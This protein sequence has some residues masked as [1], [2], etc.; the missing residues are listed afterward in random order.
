MIKSFKLAA[1]ICLLAVLLSGCGQAAIPEDISEPSLV[2]GRDG[3]VTAYLVG[4]FDKSYYDLSELAVMA[5]EEAAGFGQPAQDGAMPVTLE[6]VSAV[7]DGSGRVVVVYR[8]D[9]TDSYKGFLGNEL[10]YGTVAEAL[11][12]GFLPETVFQSVGNG[13]PMTSEALATEKDRHLIITNTAATIYCPYTV[14]HVSA[15]VT[16]NEDG[17][18]DASQAANTVYIIL[19]K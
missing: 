7:Q 10:F 1:G 2:I 14:T 19:K 4:E 11:A 9:G 13:S 5:R 12:Q 16:V 17:S 6:N 3:E 18:V 15:G 8:F